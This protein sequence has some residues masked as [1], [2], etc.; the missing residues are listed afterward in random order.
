LEDLARSL[1]DLEGVNRSPEAGVTE[2]A[3][4]RA[5]WAIAPGVLLAGAAGGIAFP[6]LPAV[7]L[8]SGLSIPF[9]GAI[10]AANRA[11]RVIT[12]PLVGALADRIGGRRTL[13]AGMGVLVVVMLMYTAGITTGRPGF[14][15][16]AGRLLHGPGSACVFVAA[17]ALALHAGGKEHGGRVA[18]LVRAALALGVPV[19]LVLGGLLSERLGNERT[20][21]G[22]AVA[23]VLAAVAAWRLVPDIRAP[24]S[25]RHTFMD[26]LRQ[27]S[28][29]SMLAIGCLN[30][31]ASFAAQGMVLTT[32]ALLVRQ[33]AVSLCGL[34]EQ[35]TSGLLLGFMILPAALAMPLAGR[36]GDRLG[37]HAAVAF[38]GMALLVPS[39]VVVG[40]TR[41]QAALIGALILMGFSVA[42]LGPSLLALVR[43]VS[44]PE[45]TGISVGLL[46]LCGDVGGT[47]GPTVGTAV[48]A[49]DITR[50]YLVSAAL[51]TLFLPVSAWLVKRSSR[52]RS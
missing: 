43:Q 33:R 27:L 20:F 6:I 9:I 52:R 38:A 15:F 46:Q 16:L 7:G 36:L 4:M 35:G 49:G 23:V 11:A 37:A 30:F 24:V 42:A 8:Q 25:R 21:E 22:A 41:S 40:L 1:Q 2:A 26:T 18:G 14:Y 31:A 13:L 44:E 48:F 45:R 5:A 32:L 51:L 34:G 39:I 17:Q 47:L 50:S 3:A 19:G 28:N 29:R 10:L 12:S